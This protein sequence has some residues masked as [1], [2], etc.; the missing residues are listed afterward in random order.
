MTLLTIRCS[1]QALRS[2]HLRRTASVFPPAG[3]AVSTPHVAKLW[4][5]LQLVR[6]L[7]A[8]LTM[9]LAACSRH[10]GPVG[11][12]LPNDGLIVV[13][14]RTGDTLLTQTD[15]PEAI[16][17]V[18]ANGQPRTIYVR[19]TV[20][21][22]DRYEALPDGEPLAVRIGTETFAHFPK[23]TQIGSHPPE[24][25]LPDT[26]RPDGKRLSEALFTLRALGHQN[27]NR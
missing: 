12:W 9:L 18:A 11:R 7:L 26:L 5:P 21:A 16:M 3:W 1:E 2:R 19:L 13:S 8:L 25:S 15:V 22:F 4:G 27:L 23:L 17:A 24:F 10:T 20:D 6:F 14:E